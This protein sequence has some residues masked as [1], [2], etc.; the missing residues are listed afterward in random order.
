MATPALQLVPAQLENSEAAPRAPAQAWSHAQ[1]CGRLTE[2]SSPRA[3]APL[4]FAMGLVLEAQL[5]GETAAW[6]GPRSASF[7][8]PDAEASGV[9][10]AAL[11]VVRLEAAQEMGR[12][13]DQLLRSGAFGLVV[14]ELGEAALPAPLLTR[15]MGLAQKYGA[16]VLFLTHKPS[17]APS[18]SSLVSLRA[19]V[20]RTR[21]AEGHFVCELRALKDKRRAPGWTHQEECCGPAGLR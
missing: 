18:L 17:E 9:D 8:P 6:I 13:A 16:A 10:L 12:A 7:F 21:R 15:L 19:E 4:T 14:V 1:L 2:L 20:S 11:A 5:A 3:G